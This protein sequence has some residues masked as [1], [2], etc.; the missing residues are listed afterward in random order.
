MPACPIHYGRNRTDTPRCRDGRVPSPP[1][2][3]QGRQGIRLRRMRGREARRRPHAIAREWAGHRSVRRA[4]G[5]RPPRRQSRLRRLALQHKTESSALSRPVV[6]AAGPQAESGSRVSPLHQRFGRHRR[7]WPAHRR[8]GARRR[9]PVD[10]PSVADVHPEDTAAIMA[11]FPGDCLARRG[12]GLPPRPRERSP[13]RAAR[14]RRFPAG[15]LL[16]ARKRKTMPCM[17][18]RPAVRV[19]FS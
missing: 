19:W 17:P 1:P 12:V 2:P 4:A 9:V 14:R 3:G 18:Y 16:V 7:H 11:E 8:R 15:E 6:A 5:P 10:N 13:R